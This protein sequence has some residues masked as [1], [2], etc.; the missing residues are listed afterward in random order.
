MLGG[1]EYRIDLAPVPAV[2]T[3]K[4]LLWGLGHLEVLIMF[5]RL[6]LKAQEELHRTLNLSQ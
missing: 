4:G 2:F 5:S 1:T 3:Y 6:C